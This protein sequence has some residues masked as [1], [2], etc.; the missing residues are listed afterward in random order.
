VN[1]C[2]ACACAQQDSEGGRRAKGEAEG[3]RESSG[4]RSMRSAFGARKIWSP[5]VKARVGW[6]L[7]IQHTSPRYTDRP[8]S[9][10]HILI[11]FMCET[12]RDAAVTSFCGAVGVSLGGTARRGLGARYG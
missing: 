2:H 4:D 1:E 5:D 11:S 9:P 10:P 6:M 8:H 12:E 3:E 7:S